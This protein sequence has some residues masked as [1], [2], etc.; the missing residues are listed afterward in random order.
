[1]KFETRIEFSDSK[2]LNEIIKKTYFKRGNEGYFSGKNNFILIAKQSKYYKIF[3]GLNSMIIRCHNDDI[4][5]DGPIR[6]I[7]HETRNGIKLYPI[8]IYCEMESGKFS[9]FQ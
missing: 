8:S 5:V 6:F 9:F 3:S 1:M 7:V 2:E 4:L